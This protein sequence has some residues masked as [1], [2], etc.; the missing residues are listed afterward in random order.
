MTTHIRLPIVII[1]LRQ[2]LEDC[3]SNTFL[4]STFVS[5]GISLIWLQLSKVFCSFFNLFSSFVTTSACAH[6]RMC[7]LHLH[8]ATPSSFVTHYIY[9]LQAW[10]LLRHP[11]L[12]LVEPLVGAR[13]RHK[14]LKL[15]GQRLFTRENFPDAARGSFFRDTSKKRVNSSGNISKKSVNLSCDL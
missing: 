7:I 8:C 15:S 10:Q 11:L 9:I 12:L 1:T 14:Y 6:V 4:V 2:K 13:Q 3:S 5:C